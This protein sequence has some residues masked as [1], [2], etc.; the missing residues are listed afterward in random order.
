MRRYRTCHECHLPIPDEDN[1]VEGNKIPCSMLHIRC[2]RCAWPVAKGYMDEDEIC[3]V[4]KG[5]FR[6][7]KK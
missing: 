2:L 6:K 3:D 4:C 1:E 5:K 7:R